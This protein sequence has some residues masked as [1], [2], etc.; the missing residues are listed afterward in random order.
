MIFQ[1][2]QKNDLNEKII[3]FNFPMYH[4]GKKKK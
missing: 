3:N 2:F 1:M 4:I